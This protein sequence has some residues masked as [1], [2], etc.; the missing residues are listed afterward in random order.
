ML[1][2]VPPGQLRLCGKG[3]GALGSFYIQWKMINLKSPSTEGISV[4]SGLDANVCCLSR[5]G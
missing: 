4:A 3:S 2:C 5:A 1:I